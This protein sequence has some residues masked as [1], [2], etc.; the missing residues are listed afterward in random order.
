MFVCCHL[1]QLQ[2]SYSLKDD[3]NEEGDYEFNI[4]SR[5]TIKINGKVVK[6][7]TLEALSSWQKYNL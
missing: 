1:Q 6:T 7:R 4:D 5:F 2:C 3:A